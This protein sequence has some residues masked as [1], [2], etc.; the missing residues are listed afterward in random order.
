MFGQTVTT[1]G[2]TM[3][4]YRNRGFAHPR[5]WVCMDIECEAG[6][7]VVPFRYRDSSFVNA[8]QWAIGLEIFLLVDDPWRVFLTTDHP[9]GAPFTSYPHLIR[10]L[11]DRSFRNDMLDTIHPEAAAMSQVGGL[12]REYSLYEIAVCT[13]AGPAR[14]LG[15]SDRGHLGEGAAADITVYQPQDDAEHMFGH[16]VLVF[17]DGEPVVKDG[18]IVKVVGGRTHVVRPDYDAGIER[19]LGAYFD[20]YHTVALRNFKISEDEMAE[21]IGSPVT[22]HPCRC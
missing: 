5:K 16:P 18:E 11:M 1:S 15:L 20:N 22:V 8:L 19:R 2:D 12:D 10:L 6:C 9:N 17:K 3:H 14:I 21:G 7:G 4:Q 13:R